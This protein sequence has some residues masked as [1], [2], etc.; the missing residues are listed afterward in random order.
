MPPQ[1]PLLESAIEL[2]PLT[3]EIQEQ[4]TCGR[5]EDKTRLWVQAVMPLVGHFIFII[6]IAAFVFFYIDDQLFNISFRAPPVTQFDGSIS[7][8]ASRPLQ[9]DITTTLSIALTLMRT[10]AAMWTAATTW[11]CVFVLMEGTGISLKAINWMT[12]FRL[13]AKPKTWRGVIV[14]IILLAAFPSQFSSPILTG[15]ITWEPALNLVRGSQPA[16]NISLSS[17]GQPW[18]LYNTWINNIEAALLI[19]AGMADT[20]WGNSNDDKA[21]M[22]RV[23]HSSQNLPINSTLNNVTVPYFT[24]DAFEWIK[25]PDSTLGDHEKGA[26]WLPGVSKPQVSATLTMGLIPDMKWG[27]SLN[28]TFP[29]PTMVSET[30]ILAILYFHG[31]ANESCTGEGYFDVPA[32]VKF[33]KGVYTAAGVTFTNCMAYARVAYT[34]GAAI[35][36]A[37]RISALTVVQTNTAVVPESD[38]M[39]ASALAIMPRLLT[40]MYLGGRAVPPSSNITDYVIRV[41]PRSYGAAW[42]ALTDMFASPAMLK[43]DVMIPV[44]M[45]QAHVVHWRVYV[46]FALNILLT[47]SGVLFIFV[48][49]RSQKPLV[50]DTAVAAL[51]L[52]TSRVL[53]N[54]QRGLCDLSRLTEEDSKIG[55]LQLQEKHGH[56]FVDVVK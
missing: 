7:H 23:L 1:S 31:E 18:S 46:W 53:V 27:P 41:L 29:S 8:A 5:H 25:D 24:V 47:L 21:T 34:A 56:R 33:Y 40:Y 9:S 36:R 50:V 44:L 17:D 48:Q 2:P 55:P 45:S 13:P 19:A 39:T 54:D 43:T 52:D 51:L 16:V 32:D 11:R 42:T 4:S 26:F 6:G 12:T 14:A 49:R 28:S 20:A 22:K 30:R 35:C 10:T 3:P 38:T 37:C 15:S